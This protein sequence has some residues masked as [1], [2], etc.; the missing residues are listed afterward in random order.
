MK[1]YAF[2]ASAWQ[3]STSNGFSAADAAQVVEV[4]ASAALQ[5]LPYL[6]KTLNIAVRPHFVGIIPE[7]GVGGYAH[8]SQFVEVWFDE[9][10]PYGIEKLKECLHQ[11][12]F[13]ELNHASR[14]N[15]TEFDPSFLNYAVS[16]GLATV[17]ERDFAAS[18]PLYGVYEN[19]ETMH[20]WYKEIA[21]GD[22]SKKEELF[23]DSSDGRRWIGYK[24]GTWLVDMAV[25]NSAK[26]V[27]ELTS[28]PCQQIIKF[29]NVT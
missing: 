27:I 18:K 10:V 26:N 12:V 11:T 4:S 8:D 6:S 7:Y 17:F 20:E 19:E 24:V 22:W 9:K 14:Y 1:V 5:V 28:L 16:E 2:E 25:K 13:H 3:V 21:S 23:F 15:T 29:A